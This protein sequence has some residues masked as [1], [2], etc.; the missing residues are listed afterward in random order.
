[1][2][3]EWKCRV[4]LNTKVGDSRGGEDELAVERGVDAASLSRLWSR[5]QPTLGINLVH[6]TKTISTKCIYNKNTSTAFIY[7]KM[8][9]LGSMS[10]IKWLVSLKG[11]ST[12]LE[13]EYERDTA[14]KWW[15]PPYGAG[16]HDAFWLDTH[17]HSRGGREITGGVFSVRVCVCV[18]EIDRQRERSRRVTAP[19]PPFHGSAQRAGVPIRCNRPTQSVW[20]RGANRKTS[21]RNKTRHSG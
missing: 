5:S 18:S 6:L 19:P 10:Q 7:H 21:L 3:L 11:F 12:S 16:E 13:H 14:R 9:A 2:V 20:K 1:M 15:L 4:K 17:P 8:N